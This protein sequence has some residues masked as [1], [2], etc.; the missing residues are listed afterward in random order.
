MS[1]TTALFDL[2]DLVVTTIDVTSVDTVDYEHLTDGQL[3]H[4]DERRQRVE[5][6]VELLEAARDALRVGAR[7]VEMGLKPGAVAPAR[8][9]RDL[10]LQ[11]AD[12]RVLGGVR[13]GSAPPAVGNDGASVDSG[14]CSRINRL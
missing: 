10:R 6:L 7:L 14:P 13:F 5:A 3:N 2:S 1:D 9:H 4:A 12:Q 11:H 8:R